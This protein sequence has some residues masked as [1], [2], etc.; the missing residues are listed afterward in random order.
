MK[1][2]IGLNEKIYSA[3]KIATV[4]EALEAEGLPA[5]E[6]I[7][8]LGLSLAETRSP[9]TRVSLTQVIK[10]CAAADRLSRDPHFAYH[11]GLRLHVS[12]YG[13]YGF[14][15]LSSTN[16][17]RTMKFVMDYYQLAAPLADVEFREE[18]RFGI[19]AFA[20]LQ[21]ADLDAR[22]TEFVIEMQFGVMTSLFRDVMGTAFAPREL[23][24]VFGP[25]DDAAQYPEIFG[26]PVL[27]GQLE[28]AMLFDS[29]WLDGAP[30]LGNEIT[31]QTVVGLCDA[32]NEEFKLRAGLAGRLRHH[33]MLNLIRPIRFDEAANA[34]NMSPRTLRRKLGEEHTSFRRVADELRAEMAIRYLRDTKLTVEDVAEL[35]GFSDAANFRHAFRRWTDGASPSAFRPDSGAQ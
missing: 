24:V 17:R 27:F 19:W 15:I 33:L 34:L 2:G 23:H 6:A 31:Y 20:P 4:L 21:D 26:G 25:P 13:M 5:E 8:G 18:G 1:I 16:Y 12:A 29:S 14:A 35:L 10:V 28:N 7:Q 9:A 3:T 11:A 22:T 32:M 30:K